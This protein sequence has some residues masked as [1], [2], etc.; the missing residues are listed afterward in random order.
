MH[1]PG[2]RPLDNRGGALYAPAMEIRDTGRRRAMAAG[3]VA[4]A[5][6]GALAALSVTAGAIPPFQMVA[7]TFT[8]AGADGAA[9]AADLASS[10]KLCLT[11]AD[12]ERYILGPGAYVLQTAAVK[13]PLALGAC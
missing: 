4:I 11:G 9:A 13:F 5:L 2:K 10:A 12:G 6:W 7:M 1:P 3:M 8:I